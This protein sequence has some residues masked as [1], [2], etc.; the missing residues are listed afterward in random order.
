LRTTAQLLL[1]LLLLLQ[2]ADTL[3]ITFATMSAIEDEKAK[4][5]AKKAKLRAEAEKLGVSY[6]VLKAQKKDNKKRKGEADKLTDDND[7]HDGGTDRRQEQKRMRTWSGENFDT[8]QKHGGDNGAKNGA[9]QPPAKRL[10]TRSMDKAEENAKIVEVEKSQS[11]E[12]WRQLHDITVRGYGKNSSE[13]K[14]ADPFIDFSD[15]PF[16]P[17]IQNTL[18]AAGFDR[19]TFI[20]S[21]VR[22][23]VHFV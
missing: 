10:R 4:K 21:Q 1:L 19:P 11:A 22:Q 3:S 15:A 18:K 17:T 8:V 14:F 20:Q 12:E 16:N 13:K 5:A 23:P 2:S 9:S 7:E 6:E